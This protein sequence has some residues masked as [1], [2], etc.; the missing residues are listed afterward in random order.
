[1]DF[2]CKGCSLSFKDQFA[3]FMHFSTNL[4]VAK[5][6]EKTDFCPST[7]SENRTVLDLKHLRSEGSNVCEVCGKYCWPFRGLAKHI[8]THVGA[9]PYFCPFC[10][11]S[12]LSK[13]H[14]QIHIFHH[15]SRAKNGNQKFLSKLNKAHVCDLCSCAFTDWKDLAIH[16]VKHLKEAPFK[17]GICCVVFLEELDFIIH[18]H[19]HKV[20][21]FCE[22][23]QVSFNTRLDCLEHVLTHNKS[24]MFRKFSLVVPCERLKRLKA[25]WYHDFFS[26]SSIC[27]QYSLDNPNQSHNFFAEENSSACFE[28]R[29]ESKFLYL[30]CP[31]TQ[32][33]SQQPPASSD[34][35]STDKF[36]N[37][38]NINF[39]VGENGTALSKA[40]LENREEDESILGLSVKPL[41]FDS[42]GYEKTL[43]RTI[44]PLEC[45]NNL[46][47]SSTNELDANIAV[48]SDMCAIETES[49]QSSV[50][51]IKCSNTKLKLKEPFVNLAE[52][53]GYMQDI[54]SCR[55]FKKKQKL[56]VDLRKLRRQ[57]NLRSSVLNKS[58]L[59]SEDESIDENLHKRKRG[60]DYDFYSMQFITNHSKPVFDYSKRNNHKNDEVEIRE[61]V[62]HLC[63]VIFE[64]GEEDVSLNCS[65][66]KKFTKC[67][68]ASEK[69]PEECLN[70]S[71]LSRSYQTSFQRKWN[72]T[73]TFVDGRYKLIKIPNNNCTKQQLNCYKDAD[74]FNKDESK[75]EVGIL[76]SDGKENVCEGN[77]NEQM[78][79]GE[80]CD[81][82]ITC[83]EQKSEELVYISNMFQKKNYKFDYQMVNSNPIVRKLSSKE[84]P[85][86]LKLDNSKIWYETQHNILYSPNYWRKPSK[87]KENKGDHLVDLVRNLKEVF[88][89]LDKLPSYVHDMPS[90]RKYLKANKN[91]NGHLSSLYQ[92]SSNLS[93]LSGKS[94]MPLK[95]K[96]TNLKNK[97]PITNIE[98]S[99]S[100]D[101]TFSDN[102]SS[103][104]EMLHRVHGKPRRQRVG[105]T[106]KTNKTNSKTKRT[107][108]KLPVRSIPQKTEEDFSSDDFT[109]SDS[110][111]STDEMLHRLPGSNQRQTNK[112]NS[113]TKRTAS[114]LPVKF[115][116]QKTEDFSFNDSLSDDSTF[117]ES[118]S[119]GE[120]LHCSHGSPQRRRVCGTRKI[121]KKN[122]KTKKTAS[123]LP[124]RS[125]PQNTLE[126]S[127]ATETCPEFF[128]DSSSGISD[129]MHRWLLNS[130]RNSGSSSSQKSALPSVRTK[131]SIPKVHQKL[132]HKHKRKPKTSLNSIRERQPF[133]HLWKLPN[134]IY[135]RHL[136]CK[137]I[138][139]S[140]LSPMIEKIEESCEKQPAT[141]QVLQDHN[142]CLPSVS[143]SILLE[144]NYC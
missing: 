60:T 44:N 11:F 89:L 23:C 138:M 128:S 2:T 119:I 35:T 101:S 70:S 51:P 58:P 140:S 130:K 106:H 65:L 27:D 98:N 66:S 57:K 33:A 16:Y 61:N 28:N 40:A 123:K 113:K 77:S 6:T 39:D 47:P 17:C 93:G 25:N 111:S 134:N 56:K 94:R 5:Q 63:E 129:F 19:L 41:E 71:I 36:G 121:N 4:C 30:N 24:K 72:F 97:T 69:P 29:E 117:S 136:K 50:H 143:S 45:S 59:F 120:M 88:I 12:S 74:T 144:H 141:S 114:K 38:Q 52:F 115:I 133:V 10:H 8:F 99:S 21:P 90:F 53:P 131:K 132:P 122:S 31:S 75:H 64:E 84:T 137:P 135:E 22:L 1:M 116:P 82:D 125:S 79:K 26:G 110:S 34:F 108:S 54:E 91:K 37:F 139:L 15:G 3:L 81:I 43:E 18:R 95:V 102:S 112:T 42:S 127:S 9:M 100:D 104:G 86:N 76:S 13:L 124:V 105:G 109:F 14:L 32:T 49:I 107:T 92:K 80:M 55:N 83:D 96:K 78:T 85:V 142:Y 103:T 68:S 48:T 7:E 62:S 118:L 87:N 46:K 67:D 20:S 126:D 73:Y